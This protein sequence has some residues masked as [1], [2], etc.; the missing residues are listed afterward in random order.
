[1]EN[2]GRREV[3]KKNLELMGCRMLFDLPWRYTDE[4][5]IKEIV[6]QK[7]TTFLATIWGKLDEWNMETLPEL[8]AKCRGEGPAPQE[9]ESGLGLLCVQP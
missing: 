1:L 5:M 9:G 7:S 4:K 2:K 6:A 8:G 3:L